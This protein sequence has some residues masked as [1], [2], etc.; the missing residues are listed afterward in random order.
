MG[1]NDVRGIAVHFAARVAA[2]AGPSEVLA[3]RTVSDLVADPGI[4]FV[5]RG[6]HR[7]HGLQEPIELHAAAT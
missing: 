1:E 2:H 3:S 7:L 4:R 5:E 6:R